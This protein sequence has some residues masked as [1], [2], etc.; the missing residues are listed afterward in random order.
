[1]R[2]RAAVLT[3]IGLAEPFATSRPIAIEEL[4]FDAPG[5]G[6]VVVRIASAGLCHS[7][8]SNLNGTIPKP[9]PLALGHEAAGVV[10]EIGPGVTQVKPGDHVVFAFIASCGHCANCVAGAPNLCIPGMAANMR[11]ELLRG[12][13][14]FRLG[15]EPVW[16]HLGVSGFA[17]RTVCAQESLVVIPDDVPLE[18]AAVFGCGALTGL[19]A[20]F[21]V[22][23]IAPGTTV[24][25]YGAGGVGLMALLGT[26]CCG[27]TAVVIDPLPHKRALAAELGAALTID[28]AAG[29]PG[30]QIRAALGVAGVDYAIEATGVPDVVIAAMQSTGAQG[31]TIVLG[32]GKPAATAPL[33]PLDLLRLDRVVR[34]S[35]MGGSVPR[36]DI[37]RYIALWRAGRLPVERL[38]SDPI[39]L[40]DLNAAFDRLAAGDVVRQMCVPAAHGA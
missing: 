19:G 7:D 23:R 20:A 33:A 4:E 34:G 24:A 29:D 30:A 22:A 2:T 25:I 1:M 12:G 28:P 27:G 35:F 10:E 18:M 31:T 36:R 6:E 13:T 26:V 8:L 14:R 5:E 32:I 21:N 3:A 37:P 39:G 11:N 40:D 15:G 16:H 17:E 38:L 9:T